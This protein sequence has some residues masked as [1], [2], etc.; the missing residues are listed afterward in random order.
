MNDDMTW[1][2]P[3]SEPQRPSHELP[4]AVETTRGSKQPVPVQSDKDSG[5]DIAWQQPTNQP[6]R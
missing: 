3:M 2:Q 6:N 5:S 4:T 1:Q